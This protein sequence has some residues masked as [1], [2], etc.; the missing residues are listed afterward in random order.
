MVLAQDRD[1]ERSTMAGAMQEHALWLG[2][3][4]LELYVLLVVVWVLPGPCPVPCRLEL[5]LCGVPVIRRSG[6]KNLP[7]PCILLGRYSSLRR[8]AHGGFSL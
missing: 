8:R 6:R 7:V 1:L 3:L 2:L 5:K 4:R